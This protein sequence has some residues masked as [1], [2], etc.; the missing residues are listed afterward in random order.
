MR[1]ITASL[2][3]ILPFL[4]FSQ[5]IK[6]LKGAINDGIV[7]NDT[8]KETFAVYLPT[9]FDIEKT[10]PVVFVIDMDGKGKQALSYLKE[11]ADA[12]G[13][14][15]ASSNNLNDSL[16][17]SQ[18]ILVAN[19]MFNEVFGMFKIKKDRTY[20]LGFS[21]G[22][23]FAS[24]IPTFINEISGVV[25]CGASVG[26]LEILNSKNP[27]Y[28][29]GIVGR[30]DYNYVDMIDTR[31]YL[32]KLNFPNQL[33]LFDG[34]HVWP[35]I[36]LIKKAMRIFTISQ[37][38]K[39]NVAKDDLFIKQSYE[40]ELLEANNSFTDGKPL[41]AENKLTNAMRV[42]RSFYDIDTLK[43]SIKLLKRS[44]SYKTSKRIQNNFFL[45]ES[46]T[47][48]DYNFYLEEDVA[49]YNYNNLGWWNF[50][51][52]EL[53]KLQESSNPFEK[54]MGKRLRGYIN[55]LIQ[56]NI[57]FINVQ[58]IADLSALEFLY[59]LQTITDPSNYDSYLK[60]ISSSSK[61]EDF[62]TALFYLEELLRNGYRDKASIYAL[63]DTALLRITPEF[64]KLIE[65]YF[66][67][68]RYK[69]IKE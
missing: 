20:T 30:E 29:I 35:E 34:G 15:M 62:G 25:S 37:M 51:M 17:I 38:E 33:L 61:V 68:A 28:F 26:N 59:M 41:L 49:T 12:E 56:D 8:V 31:Q 44:I 22:A 1:K 6:L 24:I 48:D 18:N 4:L 43:S 39:G 36:D 47:K 60:I 42:Y 27:F 16:S 5:Q 65:T 46:F 11:A 13:Y 3:F 54:Q 66:D 21:N 53:D 14:I 67:D 57:D 10:W 9:N 19:R 40:N 63:E 58:K 52:T 23:R 45:K 55:A 50:Q 64:N 32:N 69:I 7:V 2:F